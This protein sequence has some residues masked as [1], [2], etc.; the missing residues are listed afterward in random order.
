MLFYVNQRPVRD[1]ALSSAVTQAY[2]T[3]VMK[4]RYPIAVLFLELAP[5]KVDVNVHPTKAEV[6]FED[7]GEIFK[8]V[9]RGA[10]RALLAH[11]PVQ[12]VSSLRGVSLWG[13]RAPDHSQIQRGVDPAWTMLDRNREFSG[14][15]STRPR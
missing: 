9:S 5:E 13:G 10:R 1:P 15:S 6:R 14:R 8:A 2:H 12:E 4:G 3:L 11:T 7:K